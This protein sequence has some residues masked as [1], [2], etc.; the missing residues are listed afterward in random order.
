MLPQA[1]SS[2]TLE[3]AGIAAARSYIRWMKPHVRRG[4]K[5]KEKRLERAKARLASRKQAA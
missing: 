3:N 2:E 1:P 4:R 5:A